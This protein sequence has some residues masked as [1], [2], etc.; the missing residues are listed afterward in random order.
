MLLLPITEET[1][2]LQ[3]GHGESITGDLRYT[4]GRQSCPIVVI[5]HSFMAFKEWGFF[6]HLG[7]KIAEAGFSSF[8][9]NFSWNG[10]LDSQNRITDFE[11]FRQNTFSKELRDAEAVI[12]SISAGTLAAGRT[13]GRIV[14]LGHSRGGG[15]AI[16]SASRHREIQAL[17]TLA[18]ISTLDRWTTHQKKL[19]RETGSLPLSRGTSASPLRLGV[20][21][22]DD[23]EEHEANV[24][25]LAAAAR[26]DVPWL[27]VHGESDVTVPPKEAV[28]LHTAAG[29]TKA[30]LI[31]LRGTGHL[32]NAATPDEDRYSTLDH[33]I[34]IITRWLHSL[35]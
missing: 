18:A 8:T 28:A 27:I 10:V 7:R 35:F 6:P 20:E 34:G 32:F 33:A 23:L 12:A 17:V 3:T 31:M 1:I 24:N 16:L 26:V 25:V 5:C 29:P 30:E 19:W 2:V 14:F 9:F 4:L 15:I 22:L 13:D 11:R 21:L